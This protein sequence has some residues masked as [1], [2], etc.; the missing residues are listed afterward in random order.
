[1]QIL[2]VAAG[3]ITT[4]GTDGLAERPQTTP[5]IR[6]NELLS[7]HLYKVDDPT[8]KIR[9]NFLQIRAKSKQ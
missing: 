7:G 8:D 2:D 5:N 4:R 9:L 1:M 6:T 3:A